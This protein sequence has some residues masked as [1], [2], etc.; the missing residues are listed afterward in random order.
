MKEKSKEFPWLPN[1]NDQSVKMHRC[2]PK[3]MRPLGSGQIWRQSTIWGGGCHTWEGEQGI[4]W[5]AQLPW[6]PMKCTLLEGGEGYMQ[7]WSAFAFGLVIRDLICKGVPENVQSDHSMAS[8]QH[9]CLDCWLIWRRLWTSLAP[10]DT[11]LLLLANGSGKRCKYRAIEFPQD[12]SMI[13]L[14]L[15]K[16]FKNQNIILVIWCAQYKSPS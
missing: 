5:W 15:P 1:Q 6:P 16:M 7:L 14:R 13:D 2:H 11:G 4:P 3:W 10:N 9:L 8:T 12:G